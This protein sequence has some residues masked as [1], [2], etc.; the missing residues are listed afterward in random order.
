MIKDNPKSEAMKRIADA[1]AMYREHPHT[2]QE[3]KDHID[4]IYEIL[5]TEV[6]AKCFAKYDGGPPPKIIYIKRTSENQ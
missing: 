5:L 3:E 2:D 4:W 1:F 6:P